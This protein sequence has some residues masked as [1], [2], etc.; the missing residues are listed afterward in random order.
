[1]LLSKQFLLRNSTA[2]LRCW[3]WNV[4]Y[5]IGFWD[6]PNQ[7][8]SLLSEQKFQRNLVLVNYLFKSKGSVANCIT[9]R[10]LCSHWERFGTISAPQQNLNSCLHCTGATFE[11]YPVQC[12][13]SLNIKNRRK[14]S[15]RLV[16][17]WEFSWL[18]AVPLFHK[19]CVTDSR[20]KLD[21]LR[22]GIR[23]W[24]EIS[25]SAWSYN[26]YSF[27]GKILWPF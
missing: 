15:Y 20:R 18:R 7:V 8:W 19:F 27:W 14:L 23:V 9:D 16:L 22:S 13:H 10:G 12:D 11:T 4:P 1:M 2:P 6:G 3:K 26:F 24:H 5:R 25:R 21:M 17:M